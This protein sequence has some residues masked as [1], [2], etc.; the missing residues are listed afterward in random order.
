M[1]TTKAFTF[2]DLVKTHAG[3]TTFVIGKV[4]TGNYL[5]TINGWLALT[6]PGQLASAGHFA[7]V[8]FIQHFS[9]GLLDNSQIRRP[10]IAE[11]DT[12]I[13]DGNTAVPTFAALRYVSATQNFQ[14]A[15]RTAGGGWNSNLA[16]AM[17]PLP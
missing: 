6:K 2:S 4:P 5:I 1:D 17:T 8:P 12:E 3:N 15:C 9:C 16:K 14:L 13:T 7:R 10:V 11:S